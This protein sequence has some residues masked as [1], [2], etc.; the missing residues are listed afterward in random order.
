[1]AFIKRIIPGI[2]KIQ[3]SMPFRMDQVNVY[4]LEGK[5]LTLIDTGPIME[6]SLIHI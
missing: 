1:M 3:L 6:L 5:P 4:L 2:Y